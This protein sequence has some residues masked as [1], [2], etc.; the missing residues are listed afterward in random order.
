MVV[1]A[2]VAIAGAGPLF[3]WLVRQKEREAEQSRAWFKA[4]IESSQ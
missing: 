4:R 3:L 2:I 1:A